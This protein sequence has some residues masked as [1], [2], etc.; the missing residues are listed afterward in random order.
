[1][2]DEIV[3]KLVKDHLE[4]INKGWILDGFP[5]TPRQATLLDEALASWNQKLSLALY[6]NVPEKAIIER[7]QGRYVHEKSGRVYNTTYQ[8]P[9]KPGI[10]DLT[11]EPLVQ[12]PD[13]KPETV[14]KRLREYQQKTQPLIEFYKS[15]NKLVEIESPTSDIGYVKIKKLLE[16]LL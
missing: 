15:Q 8:P 2:P 13:D 9:K 3:L 6:L 14:L 7:I 12:R 4:K 10:D 16:S 11:G 5:R 1:M